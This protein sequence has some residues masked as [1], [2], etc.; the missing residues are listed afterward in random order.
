MPNHVHL[1]VVL[2]TPMGWVCTWREYLQEPVEAN[3]AAR[4]QKL[5][6]TGHPLREED[7]IESVGQHIGRDLTSKKPGSKPE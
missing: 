4:L 7:F 2:E 6:Y 1:S 3:L 5:E